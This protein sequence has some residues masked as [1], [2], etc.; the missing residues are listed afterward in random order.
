M[1]EGRW[2]PLAWPCSGD[3]AGRRD[4]VARAPRLRA[5]LQPAGP[6]ALFSGPR[7]PELWGQQAGL[8]SQPPTQMC[9]GSLTVRLASGA[10]A[11]HKV[12]DLRDLPLGQ[13]RDT[14]SGVGA[15]A[16]P[17]P[18]SRW[19]PLCC[20]GHR[21]WEAGTL[22]HLGRRLAG[23]VE[24]REGWAAGIGDQVLRVTKGTVLGGGW[25]AT[26]SLMTLPVSQQPA[27][28][29]AWGGEGPGGVGL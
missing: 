27:G 19:G 12:W 17:K 23:C 5:E 16:G 25:G 28:G 4:H 15:S 13:S 11:G 18:T 20:P 3:A 6:P 29:R 8:P 24:R 10:L 21:A 22:D 7:S 14:T 26:G 2:R 1:G 9:P